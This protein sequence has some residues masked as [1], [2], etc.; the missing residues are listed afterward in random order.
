M[1]T[2]LVAAKVTGCT[3]AES[4]HQTPVT[5][6]L[7]VGVCGAVS[8]SCV[9]LAVRVRVVRVVRRLALW[10]CTLLGELVRGLSSRVLLV[11]ETSVG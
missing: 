5:L 10:V 8:A 11:T 1:P 4:T 9:S 3:S 7:R 2:H 6:L